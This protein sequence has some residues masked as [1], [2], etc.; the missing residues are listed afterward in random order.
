MFDFVDKSVEIAAS[1]L[2][3]VICAI[4][5]FGYVANLVLL[6]NS[7]FLD[8]MAVLR[9]VG[10]FIWPLGCVMGWIS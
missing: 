3:V 8:G 4:G 9:V 2:L 1:V 7:A 5:I 6:G 10:I